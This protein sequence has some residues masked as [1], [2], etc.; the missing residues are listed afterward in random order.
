MN[1]I[2]NAILVKLVLRLFEVLKELVLYFSN[3]KGNKSNDCEK[4]KERQ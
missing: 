3:Q 4:P 2:Q 1:F